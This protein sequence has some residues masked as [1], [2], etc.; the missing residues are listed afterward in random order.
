M[1][2]VSVFSVKLRGY[3]FKIAKGGPSQ[4]ALVTHSQITNLLIYVIA[5]EQKL[6]HKT[7]LAFRLYKRK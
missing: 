3:L 6:Q 5:F 4:K 1:Y 2:F 7:I